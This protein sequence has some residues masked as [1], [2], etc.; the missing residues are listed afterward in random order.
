[1]NEKARD[2]FILKFYKFAKKSQKCLVQVRFKI[3]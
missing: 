3:H 1:M 2:H